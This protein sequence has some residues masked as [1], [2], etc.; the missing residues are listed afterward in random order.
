MV[1]VAGMVYLLAGVIY[2]Q[3]QGMGPPFQQG[4]FMFM[5]SLAVPFLVFRLLRRLQR[6]AKAQNNWETP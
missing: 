2:F 3:N 1:V 4:I 6:N 5:L